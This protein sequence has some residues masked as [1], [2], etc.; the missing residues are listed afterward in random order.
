MK[1]AIL[2][3]VRGRALGWCTRL[4]ACVLVA[5]TASCVTSRNYMVCS[6]IRED[7]RFA[8]FDTAY[9]SARSLKDKWVPDSLRSAGLT[10]LSDTLVICIYDRPRFFPPKHTRICV[11]SASEGPAFRIP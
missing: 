8:G 2:S 3:S 1:T 9:V 4:I 5:V 6:E 7:C 11:K 10:G